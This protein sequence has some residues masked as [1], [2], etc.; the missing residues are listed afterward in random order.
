MFVS[1]SQCL[2]RGVLLPELLVVVRADLL[3]HVQRLS[4]QL[5]LDDLQELVLL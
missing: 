1:I 2:L 5:L 3:D 4:D